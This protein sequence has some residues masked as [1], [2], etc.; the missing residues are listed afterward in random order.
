MFVRNNQ[1][2]TAFHAIA[3]RNSEFLCAFRSVC[4]VLS[5]LDW[6]GSLYFIQ[7]RSS[8]TSAFPFVFTH[9]HVHQGLLLQG[10]IQTVLATIEIVFGFQ[11]GDYATCTGFVSFFFSNVCFMDGFGSFNPLTPFSGTN[12]DVDVGWLGTIDNM[13]VFAIGRWWP[14]RTRPVVNEGFLTG[15]SGNVPQLFCFAVV[16]VKGIDKRIQ[17]F[18][19]WVPEVGNL[20]GFTIST[21]SEGGPHWRGN[22]WHGTEHY[23]VFS[24]RATLLELFEVRH[25]TFVHVFFGETWI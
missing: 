23:Q 10:H 14:R 16:R 5:R 18:R 8:C 19:M 20:V 2:R 3:Y 22:G 15:F 7:F 13:K 1:Y 9:N 6:Q 12:S 25:D 17:F 21:G 4:P 24:R 11:I